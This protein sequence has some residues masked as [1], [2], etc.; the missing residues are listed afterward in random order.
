MVTRTPLPVQ[1]VVY[2]DSKRGSSFIPVQV[3][4]LLDKLEILI[5]IQLPKG[6]TLNLTVCVQTNLHTVILQVDLGE[7]LNA[8]QLVTR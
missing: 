1:S 5:N 8:T 2:F 7:G 4:T 3:V 6:N